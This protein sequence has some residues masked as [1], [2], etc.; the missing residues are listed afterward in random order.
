MGGDGGNENGNEGVWRAPE[1][2]G[3]A[4]AG[5]AH[6]SSAP[7]TAR[8]A[9]RSPNPSLAGAAPRRRRG[10]LVICVRWWWP[11]DGGWRTV[12][13]ICGC[14]AGGFYTGKRDPANPSPTPR[15][16]CDAPS[17]RPRVR[18]SGGLGPDLSPRPRCLIYFYFF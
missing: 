3:A 2:R 10:V 5:R 16:I 9:R 15:R 18:Y 17:R 6:A 11:G 12:M 8:A 4:R 1:G 14:G 13:G 7:P